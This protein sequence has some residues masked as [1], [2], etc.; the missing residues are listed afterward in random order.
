[1]RGVLH[2][3]WTKFFSSPWCVAGFIAAIFIAPIVLP[4]MVKAAGYNLPASEVLA[5]CLRAMQ[6]G[7]A[8]VVI[9]AAAFWG[10]EYAS[11][12]MRTTLLVIPKRT[13]MIASKLTILAAAAVLAGAAS[14]L[15]G[16]IVSAAGLH[17]EINFDIAAEFVGRAIPAMV[18]WIQMAWIVSG[19]SILTKSMII[20]IALMLSFILGVSQMLMSFTELAKYLPDLAAMNLFTSTDTS[21]FLAPL[22][23]FMVQLGWMVLL[24]ALGV[25][26]ILRRDVR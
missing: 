22:P 7:Q 6:L 26:L 19:F 15:L 2:S 10:Q 9:A 23:G 18:S 13:L 5:L 1:M 25:C 21:L 12:S 3:E 24:T 16:V 14:S 20:P 11:S 17:A 4:F 8:G